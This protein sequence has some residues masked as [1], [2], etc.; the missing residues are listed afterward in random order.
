MNDAY[1]RASM[2]THHGGAAIPIM[3]ATDAVH[4]HSNLGCATIFPHNIGL[5]ATGDLDLIGRIA[6]ITAREVMATGVD[7]VLGP[8]AS[9][10]RDCRWGRTFESYSSDPATV[11]A[12]ASEFVRGVQSD[13]QGESLVACAKHWVGDGGTRHGI[14]QGDATLDFADLERIH[15]AAY[16]PALRDGVLT[17]M[18]SFNSWN[19]DKCHGSKFLLTDVLKGKLGFNGFIV[20]DWDGINYLS[21][22]Y[23][24]A[25][26]MAVNAGI[27][28][29]MVPENW[30]EFI[31]HLKRH[32][33]RGSVSIRR[34]DDAVRRI[35]TVKLAAGLF[36]KP[37]PRDRFWTNNSGLGSLD[38]RSAAR[39][40]VRKSLVLLKNEKS[41]LPLNKD[42]RVFVAGKNAD[43]IGHQCGGFSINWQ[44]FCGNE[45]ADQGTSM[46]AAISEVAP[47]AVLSGDACGADAD[48]D[49]HDV[50]VVVVGEHPY[51][52][53]QGD[54]RD[55]NHVIVEAG[56][57]IK[58]GFNIL[59]PYGSSLRLSELHPEDLRTI[60][61][62]AA[63]GI[64]VVVV[65]V[66]GRP[67]VVDEELLEATAFVAAWLPGSEGQGVS[68][69]L[70]GDFDFQGTLSFAWPKRDAAS[71]G[72]SDPTTPLFQRGYGLRYAQ[73]NEKEL[74]NV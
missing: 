61:T 37:R 17:I 64:P 14:D 46:W 56:S 55:G 34:I 32:V 23:H 22:D 18:A 41:L 25:V 4:G 63:K 58:G 62:I 30:P 15:I 10:V 24:L 28:M 50:A 16:L 38:H 42:S 45:L 3:Y 12:Y 53:G 59:K 26:A 19:G 36:E 44:G 70:F 60:K 33:E 72:V 74:A 68:D 49:A 43:N 67:L 2:D 31:R 69:V 20:S 21:E 73:C 51:A 65:L 35:L 47:N 40:A 7:W 48:P 66:S 8:P 13:Q 39:E 52:E 27:D 5:G 29:I 6:R 9:V 57:Q 11:A 71:A 1:W 54:I